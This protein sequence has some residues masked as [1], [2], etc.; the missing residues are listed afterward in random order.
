MAAKKTTSGEKFP[1]FPIEWEDDGNGWKS[2]IYTVKV[3]EEKRDLRF[4]QTPDGAIGIRSGRNKITM[5]GSV[6]PLL[7]AYET[8]AK[9]RK[10]LDAQWSA[11]V[12]SAKSR[13]TTGTKSATTAALE[14]LIATQN[15][16]MQQMMKKLN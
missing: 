7:V 8:D 16:M 15:L 2:G 4:V 12:V 6:F 5:L 1:S 3:G 10:A 14:S 9:L 11:Y 13:K